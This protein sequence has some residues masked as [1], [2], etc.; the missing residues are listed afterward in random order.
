MSAN[1]LHLLQPDRVTEDTLLPAAASRQAVTSALQALEL[2]EQAR[3]DREC[4]RIAREVLRDMT[5]AAGVRKETE[6]IIG[7]G[8]E[9]TLFT[10]RTVDQTVGTIIREY[11]ETPRQ[12]AHQELIR[13]FVAN[14][15]A[16]YKAEAANLRRSFIPA[17]LSFRER[18]R[19]I[20]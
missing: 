18:R 12:P 5:E 4:Q 16:E 7:Q 1:N 20:F 13:D 6:F 10:N 15:I 8:A 9:L 17:I 2:P 19:S 11:G 14:G 3:R